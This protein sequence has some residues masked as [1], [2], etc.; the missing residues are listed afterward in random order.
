MF[1]T[2]VLTNGLGTQT[3]APRSESAPRRRSPPAWPPPASR[4]PTSTGRS[5]ELSLVL[6]QQNSSLSLRG[7]VVAGMIVG[8][9][10]VLADTPVTQASAV[11]ALRRA[12]PGLGARTLYR[13]AFVVGRDHLSA[14]IHTHRPGPR[15]DG[16]AAPAHFAL[17]QS[18]VHGRAQCPGRGR[19]RGR[20]RRRVRG[21]DRRRAAHDRAGVAAPRP[22]ATRAAIRRTRAQPR[23]KPG[24]A[25]SAGGAA[26]RLTRT[27]R[28]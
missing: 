19:A 6:G 11:M 12:D 21:A 20:R 26:S 7:V 16:A 27:R 8:A 4:S 18:R 22:P 14:T 3:L 23:M 10:G 1:V 24:P 13:R 28:P 2:L 25:R 9:L 15:G 17:E 5:N